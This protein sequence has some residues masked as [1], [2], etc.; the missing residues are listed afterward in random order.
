MTGVGDTAQP[1]TNPTS[2]PS[3]LRRPTEKQYARRGG[4]R[5]GK[6]SSRVSKKVV[7]AS[8][9]D[10]ASEDDMDVGT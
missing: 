10:V 6:P 3:S 2:K 8:D 5:I 1:T 9:W 7:R 4:G